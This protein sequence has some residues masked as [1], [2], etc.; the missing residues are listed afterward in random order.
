MPGLLQVICEIYGREFI[1]LNL[2]QREEFTH[3]LWEKNLRDLLTEQNCTAIW[4]T[5][6]KFKG[7]KPTINMEMYHLPC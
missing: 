7:Q 3:A 5:K 1:N 4:R 2:W 6:F